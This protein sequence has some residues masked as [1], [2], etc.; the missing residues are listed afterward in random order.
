MMTTKQF[1]S[2]CFFFL[3]L[4][5]LNQACV[6]EYSRERPDITIPIIDTMPQQQTPPD[7][8]STDTTLSSC[9]ACAGRDKFEE[10][11]W[12]FKI[13]NSFFCGIIDTAITTPNR[14]A[15]TFFG[16]SACSSDTSLIISVYMDNIL[17]NQDRAGLLISR[18]AFYYASLGVIAYPLISRTGSPFTIT[19]NSYDHRTK[20]TTGT[21]TG[22]AYK[23]DGSYVIISSGKFKVKLH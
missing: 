15:F 8:S 16:P 23:P 17:L 10:G 21:F 14:N 11:I 1:H 18:V 13:E 3:T 5:I 12:S 9:T 4:L 22:Y 20:M 6:K 7:T 2:I 19:I